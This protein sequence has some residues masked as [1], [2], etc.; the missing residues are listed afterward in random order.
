MKGSGHRYAGVASR[1]V[2]LADGREVATQ[3][4]PPEANEDDALFFFFF[5]FFI[6]FCKRKIINNRGH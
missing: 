4:A 5:L 2:T 1:T 6:C 3:S